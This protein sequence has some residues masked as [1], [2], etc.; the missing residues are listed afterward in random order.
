MPS[1]RVFLWVL[2]CIQNAPEATR[3]GL[4]GIFVPGYAPESLGLTLPRN[5][6]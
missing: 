6:G 1:I 2:G 5:L 4:R 3:G